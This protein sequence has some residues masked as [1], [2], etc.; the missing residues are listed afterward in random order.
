VVNRVDENLTRR[1]V[2]KRQ[3]SRLVE[4]VVAAAP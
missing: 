4:R 1:S 3:I 2:D